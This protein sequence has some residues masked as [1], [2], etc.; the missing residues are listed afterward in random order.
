MDQL[1]NTFVVLN[2]ILFYFPLPISIY[3]YII[4]YRFC[5]SFY[6]VL[7]N[8]SIGLKMVDVK[9]IIVLFQVVYTLLI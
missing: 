7:Y 5:S 6:Q 3:L 1:T 9:Y 8:K 4:Y 2:D